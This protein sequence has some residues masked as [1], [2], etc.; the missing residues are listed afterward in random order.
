[1]L[2]SD[3][4]HVLDSETRLERFDQGDR[5]RAD[6]GSPRP[7]EIVVT[8][9][10]VVARSGSRVIAPWSER[11]RY[12]NRKNGYH[13]GATPQEVVVPLFGLAPLDVEVE[14]W[15]EAPMG[16]PPWWDLADETPPVAPVRPPKRTMLP[17]VGRTLP[18]EFPAGPAADAR[19][20][21]ALFG[22]PVY[23]AQRRLAGRV[24]PPDSRV[25]VVLETLDQRGG[26]LT[27]AALSHRLDQPHVRVNGLI[28]AMRRLL[29][30]EG[31]PILSVDEPSD[32]VELNRELLRVQ[33]GL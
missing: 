10:R 17:E 20:L 26:K 19:W 30:V 31:Y 33:F 7:D 11:T 28:A 21:D 9:P 18:F 14:G 25:R 23:A 24:A 29:N 3:H 4:G 12:G 5:W 15:V 2:T 16:Y 8:G 13:G 27:R 32:T 1:V 22:S 6:D